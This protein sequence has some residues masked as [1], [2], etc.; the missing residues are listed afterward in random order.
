MKIQLMNFRVRKSSNRMRIGFQFIHP[1]SIFEVISLFA[2]SCC[3]FI[4]SVQLQMKVNLCCHF[5]NGMLFGF[6]FHYQSIVVTVCMWQGPTTIQSCWTVPM[7]LPDRTHISDICF[8]PFKECCNV[9]LILTAGSKWTWLFQ[10]SKPALPMKECNY[11]NQS[12]I[13]M[14]FL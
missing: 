14:S 12:I 9:V 4:P 7:F 10:C 3:N 1:R 5:N 11:I 13:F 6:R 8:L 2:N